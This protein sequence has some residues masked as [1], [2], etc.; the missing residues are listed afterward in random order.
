MKKRLI[1]LALLLCMLFSCALAE[2]ARY[3]QVYDTAQDADRLTVRY[4]WLGPQVADDKP[5]D[6]MIL[7]SP[8]GKIMVLDAGH[9]QATQYIIAALDA[10]GVK[11]ID[12]LV[13][14]HPHIDHIGGMAALMDRYEVGIHYST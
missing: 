7:T 11:K 10:M 12:Y 8:D 13:A 3:G 6:C 1:A 9:P 4:L 5:G 2:D 14:S